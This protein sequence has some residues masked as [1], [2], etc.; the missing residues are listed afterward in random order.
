MM[1]IML[2]MYRDETEMMFK[3]PASGGNRQ[4]D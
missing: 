4:D 3:Q 2:T 1:L